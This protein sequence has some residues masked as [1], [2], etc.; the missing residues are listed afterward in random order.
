MFTTILAN[1]EGALSDIYQ[2]VVKLLVFHKEEV[3]AYE[4]AIQ[5]LSPEKISL[6]EKA[7]DVNPLEIPLKYSFLVNVTD[8]D[9]TFEMQRQT[10]L[11]IVQ[12]MNMYF[13]RMIQLGQLLESGQL[14]TM[15]RSIVSSALETATRQMQEVL[16]LFGHEE[17]TDSLPD[18]RKLAV[19]RQFA[20]ALLIQDLSKMAQAMQAGPIPA[21]PG[22]GM[23]P[24]IQ[25][26]PAPVQPMPAPAETGSGEE[27][28][29]ESSSVGV[30][31]L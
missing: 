25:A 16:R 14:G 19:L 28:Q 13:E 20:E 1:Y 23:A 2:K 27:A 21:Q 7:L 22:P 15:T 3:L 17:N 6:L 9:E 10:V 5:R 29:A 24:P 11:T 18:A 12:I 4:R 8:V 30:E 26:P 31:N